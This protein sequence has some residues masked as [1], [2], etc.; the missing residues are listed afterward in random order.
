LA[1]Q[2]FSKP[3]RDMPLPGNVNAKDRFQRS[4]Y[5]LAMLPEPKNEREAVAGILAV[6]RNV[7]VP[8]GAPYGEFG[9]YNTDYRTAVN[10]SKRRYYFEL[11]TSPNVIWAD[12]EDFDLSAGA[13][14]MELNPDN[15]DLSGNVTDKFVQQ[16]TTPF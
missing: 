11:T 3:S 6:V 14:V 8:F 5:Y 7:S 16:T 4:A 13:P 12:L 2:D 15:I 10:L 1:E 9:I